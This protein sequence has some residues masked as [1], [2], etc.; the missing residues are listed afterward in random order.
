[1]VALHTLLSNLAFLDPTLFWPFSAFRCVLRCFFATR[2]ARFGTKQI[3]EL[4]S[5]R[6]N[7]NV[8]DVVPLERH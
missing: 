5:M 7:A 1:M 6:E 8:M 3:G 4:F 2:W